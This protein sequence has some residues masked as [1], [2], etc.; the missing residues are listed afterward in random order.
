MLQAMNT[1]HDGSLTTV[2]ANS[3]EEAVFRLENMFLMSG[4]EVPISAIRQQIGMAIQLIVQQRRLPD[5]TR[6]VTHVT[7]VAGV[8]DG[9]VVTQD[10]FAFEN[11]RLVDQ[12]TV[13]VHADKLKMNLSRLP[14]LP[15]FDRSLAWLE[16][17]REAA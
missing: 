14:P 9:Q 12:G 13:I 11:G 8:E 3:P 4:L 7:Q 2:H 10:L 16:K 1:G 6:K 17:N 5:G 15:I